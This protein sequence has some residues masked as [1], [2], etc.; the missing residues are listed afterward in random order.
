M[1][2]DILLV[3]ED[4][5]PLGF[6][7]ELLNEDIYSVSLA[8]A[9]RPL[10]HL[11]ERRYWQPAGAIVRLAGDEILPDFEALFDAYPSTGFVFL[12][13]EWLDADLRQIVA[14]RGGTLADESSERPGQI[15]ES[16]I[17]LLFHRELH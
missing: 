16:L 15:V 9:R 4:V 5:R 11:L 3:G 7:S 2:R 17:A 13:A 6:L 1:K 10:D 12:N 8:H 14:Q